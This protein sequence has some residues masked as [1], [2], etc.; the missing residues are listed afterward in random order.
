MQPV[1]ETTTRRGEGHEGV[2]LRQ[3]DVLAAA[4]EDDLGHALGNDLGVLDGRDGAEE[5]VVC[6][7][8]VDPAGD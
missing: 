5:P 3:E 8:L 7:S 1:R 4:G 2:S 6:E